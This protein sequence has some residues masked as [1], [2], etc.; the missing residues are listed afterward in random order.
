MFRK[1]SEMIDPTKPYNAKN[2]IFNKTVK[3]NQTENQT[4]PGYLDI[5]VYQDVENTP[6][7]DATVRIFKVLYLGLFDESAEGKLVAEYKTDKKGEIPIIELPVLNE[8]QPGDKG[9]YMIAVHADDFYSAYIFRIQLYPATTTT[10]KVQLIPIS[11][12]VERFHFIIQPT[13][14]RIHTQ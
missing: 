8:L 1:D 6:I 9:F 13:T 12:G 10:F 7:R 3:Y 11:S 5:S 14:K 4:Q 2:L